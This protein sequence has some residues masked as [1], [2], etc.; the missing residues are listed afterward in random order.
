MNC[1]VASR[2]LLSKPSHPFT[3]FITQSQYR[4]D[5]GQSAEEC[6]R[7]LERKVHVVQTGYKQT[8]SFLNE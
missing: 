6:S 3:V 2:D 8:L 5:V 1:C 7:L 4:F